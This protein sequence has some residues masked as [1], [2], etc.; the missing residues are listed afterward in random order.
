LDLFQNT[1]KHLFF[2]FKVPPISLLLK[3][4]N[5]IVV[6]NTITVNEN[7]DLRLVC[8]G[9]GGMFFV[10]LFLMILFFVLKVF[11]FFIKIN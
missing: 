5:G 4:M 8:E 7:E 6:N 10:F 2:F 3:D 11:K 9:Y 1:E